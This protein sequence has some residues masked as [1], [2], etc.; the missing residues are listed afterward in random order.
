[1]TVRY[2]STRTGDIGEYA[3][4]FEPY[5]RSDIWERLPEP[6]PEPEAPK[7]RARKPRKVNRDSAPAEHESGR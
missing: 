4:P 1:M 6:E 7:P 5:E 3:E 2:R